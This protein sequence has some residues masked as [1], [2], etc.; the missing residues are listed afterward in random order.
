MRYN[1]EKR[2]NKMQVV[3]CRNMKARLSKVKELILST[4]N[5]IGNVHFVKRSDGKKRRMSYRVHV[6][7]PSYA[8]EPTGKKFKKT[9][10]RDSD[11]FQVTVFDTNKVLYNKKGIMCGRG[12]W[13]AIP[14]ETVTRVSVGG[15]IY[16]I[17]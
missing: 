12:A 11:N 13:R 8:A 5:Q 7:K 14:L 17:V 3:K 10:D 16:R 6:R 2:S 9:V 4:G 15:E 1:V